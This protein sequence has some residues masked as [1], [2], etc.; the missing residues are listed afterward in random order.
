MK[1]I[2][3]LPGAKLSDVRWD[4]GNVCLPNTRQR[5]LDEIVSWIDNPEEG[6]MFWLHGVAGSGKSTIGNTIAKIFADL[7]R[8][9]GS[10]RFHRDVQG[11]NVPTYFFGN[12]AYQLAHF[13]GQL[14]GNVVA[15]IKVHGNM[16]QWPLRNQ[17]KTFI[18][19][20]LKDVEFAGPIVILIDGLDECE[21]ESARNPLLESIVTESQNIP[22][23]VKFLIISRDEADIQSKL[24]TIC[25]SRSINTEEDTQEDIIK[26]IDHRMAQ[27]QRAYDLPTGWPDEASRYKLAW[28][29]AGLFIWAAIACKYI[30]GVDPAVQLDEMLSGDIPE[31]SNAETT[32]DNLYL[33]I[34]QRVCTNISDDIFKYVV[35]SILL[36]KTPLT[37]PALDSLLGLGSHTID[38]PL[39]LSGGTKIKCTSSGLIIRRLRS[40]LQSCLC[41]DS[42]RILHPSLFDF[43]TNSHRCTNL[44]FFID[45]PS[46]NMHLAFRCFAVMDSLLKR[47]ICGINDPTKLN[48]EV[49]DLDH[50]LEGNVPEHL[51]YACLYW[52][53]HLTDLPDD[54]SGL[55]NKVRAFLFLHL[56]HWLEVMSLLNMIDAAFA[57]LQSVKHWFQ[58]PFLFS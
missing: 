57:M 46:Q 40:I 56:L 29:S 15:A 28:H 8:L 52:V 17:M 41:H 47:D 13:N 2:E 3:D 37:Q 32:L 10:F 44:Q 43:L 55:Y 14:L 12:L 20:V 7:G 9:A 45:T 25:T 21:G 48:Y 4:L 31:Q 6:S 38:H 35:G 23:F 54:S 51:I 33:D 27:I 11:C 53:Q 16:S 24:E 19:D 50:R 5:L 1:V 34:L 42:I 30:E 39:I 22:R 26:F 58:V 18:V 49:T 36:V